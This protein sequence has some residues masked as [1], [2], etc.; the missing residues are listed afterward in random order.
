[1]SPKLRKELEKN[2][3]DMKE[4][5]KNFK[6]VASIVNT[7]E[8]AHA[9]KKL[10]MIALSDDKEWLS[11]EEKSYTSMEDRDKFYEKVK[12]ENAE[13]FNNYHDHREFDYL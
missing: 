4:M 10:W 7:E 5:D 11:D 8:D 12:T 1:M 9:Y 13:L 3:K 6:K 2:I